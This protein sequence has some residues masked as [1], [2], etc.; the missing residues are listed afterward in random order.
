MKR[1][2]SLTS[3][4][5][6]IDGVLLFFPSVAGFLVLLA[7]TVLYFFGLRP[8]FFRQS[9]QR[10]KREAWRIGL[11]ALALLFPVAF[12][13]RILDPE[14]DRQFASMNGLTTIAGT[15][16]F[17][18]ALPFLVAREE[19]F[20]RFF[21]SVLSERIP[22]TLAIVTVAIHGALLHVAVGGA[23]AWTVFFSVVAGLVVVGWVYAKTKNIWV[24]LATHLAYDALL[25][26]QILLHVHRPSLEWLF[27]IVY[28]TAF[29]LMLIKPRWPLCA[30]LD[31][32]TASLRFQDA[33]FV[34]VLALL[35][36]LVRLAR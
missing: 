7:L 14:F 9:F 1:L 20:F 13:G 10:P 16:S 11:I 25:L 36:L 29:V 35:P 19:L 17:L 21:Q 15:F 6:L 33:L 32:K 4:L 23:S 18:L 28:F 2:F 34:L 27:W 24:A 22:S 5:L 26:G 31:D 12:L 8:D 30:A 3:F